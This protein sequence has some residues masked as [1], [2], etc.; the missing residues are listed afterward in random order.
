MLYRI[1]ESA[2]SNVVMH[3]KATE[4]RISLRMISNELELE[5]ADNGVG[6]LYNELMEHTSHGLMLMRERTSL[7]DGRM[8]ITSEPGEGTIVR[9]VVALA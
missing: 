8:F 6:F 5:I 4:V 1:F 3:S 9:I 7:L 2:M